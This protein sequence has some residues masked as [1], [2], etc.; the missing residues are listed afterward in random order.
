[1]SPLGRRFFTDLRF[2]KVG[3]LVGSDVSDYLNKLKVEID[4]G[5]IFKSID[6]TKRTIPSTELKL[7]EAHTITADDYEKLV[8]E[9]AVKSATE[10]ASVEDIL[11]KFQ[12]DSGEITVDIDPTAQTQKKSTTTVKKVSKRRRRISFRKKLKRRAKSW[13]KPSRGRGRARTS[14]GRG[15]LRRSRT[16]RKRSRGR[17][18]GRRR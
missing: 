13:G 8:M 4:I 10:A 6:V 7:P 18:R 15:G 9:A 2:G 3:S 11:A 1:M 12:S 5:N 16:T 17:R 14:K